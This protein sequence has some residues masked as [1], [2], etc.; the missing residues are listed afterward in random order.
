MATCLGQDY[1]E[2]QLEQEP[3]VGGFRCL[4]NT[5][6]L[7]TAHP[8]QNRKLQWLLPVCQAPSSW[9]APPMSALP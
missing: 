6:N 5:A 7:T 3:T 8:I 9:A 1:L 4:A 2:Q